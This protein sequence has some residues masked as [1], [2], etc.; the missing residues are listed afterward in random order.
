VLLVDD[1]EQFVLNM[2]K[3]LKFRGFEVSTALDGFKALELFKSGEGFDVVVLDEKMSGMDGISALSRI[4]KIAPHT[5]V[6]MLT[7]HATLE[8]GIEAIRWGAFDY[9]MKPCDIEDLTEK[10]K[11]A[12][13]VE[14]IKHRPVLWPRNLVKDI[15]W[16][17]FIR[18]ETRD[19]I[20]KALEVF[21]RG[22]GMP[23]KEALYILDKEDRF[24]GIITRRDLIDAARKA[25]PDR[26]IAWVDLIEDPRL[27]PPVIL[28]DVMRPDH[29]ITA[30]PEEN[31]TQVAHRMITDKI[32]S[33][34]VVEGEK[35]KGFIRLQDIFQYVEH[36]IR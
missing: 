15:A 24:Q 4:K 27:L 23:A 35:V 16:P 2:S 6:I 1:E 5:E 10:I 22:I 7:G 32:R 17:S 9:L 11:E 19:P 13:E 31:L 3:L 30:D 25:H 18:L 8:S 20:A 12:C 29:P 14:R 28:G 21:K 33:M 26:V 36:K 34:P